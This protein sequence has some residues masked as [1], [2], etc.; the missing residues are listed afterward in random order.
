MDPLLLS[1]THI[2]AACAVV[3]LAP[4]SFVGAPAMAQDTGDDITCISDFYV[5][6]S[7][8]IYCRIGSLPQEP[9]CVSKHLMS[10]DDDPDAF[11][12][13]EETVTLQ[14]KAYAAQ[15]GFSFLGD[16]GDVC[17]VADL[18]IAEQTPIGKLLGDGQ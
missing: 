17:D 5:A 9:S 16:A 1:R 3:V 6:S 7:M 12:A 18:E 13:R 11:F 10:Y 14:A 4:M 8:H 2:L 15:R